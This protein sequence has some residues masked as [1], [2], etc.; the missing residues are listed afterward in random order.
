MIFL[1]TIKVTKNFR[2][3][4]NNNQNFELDSG[5]LKGLDLISAGESKYHILNDNRSYRVEIIRADFNK[6][7]YTI[8]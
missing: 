2:I 6:K 4:V 1:K 7:E 5:S 8:S 3:N